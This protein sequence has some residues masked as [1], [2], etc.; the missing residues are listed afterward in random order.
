MKMG[1]EKGEKEKDKGFSVSWAGGDFGPACG[2][3][4]ELAQTAHERGEMA[5]VDAVSAGPRVRERGS[6]DGIRG[7]NRP[8][9]KTGRRRGSATVLRRGSGSGWL[10]R[11]ATAARGRGSWWQGQFGR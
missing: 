10:G 6:T 9:Q 8:G 5:R 11:W 3:T 4:G 1:K 2:A 7:A